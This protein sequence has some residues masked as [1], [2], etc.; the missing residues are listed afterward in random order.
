MWLYRAG[1]NPPLLPKNLPLNKPGQASALFWRE[2]YEVVC[3]CRA[4]NL[5]DFS[6][7]RKGSRERRSF[8]SLLV[9]MV[10]PRRLRFSAA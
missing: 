6:G 10:A 8:I 3:V 9:L 4:A 2:P 1:S 5:E 7:E